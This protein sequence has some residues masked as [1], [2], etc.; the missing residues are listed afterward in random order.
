[1]S[2]KANSKC[3]RRPRR[4]GDQR[5]FKPRHPTPHPRCANEQKP[6]PLSVIHVYSVA[7]LTHTR[8]HTPG[9]SC[10]SASV[11]EGGER[12]ETMI[13]VEFIDFNGA[14]ASSVC[15]LWGHL[16]S[17]SSVLW[18]RRWGGVVSNQ[19]GCCRR[20]LIRCKRPAGKRPCSNNTL[21]MVGG[22]VAGRGGV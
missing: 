1:M 21:A 2:R 13:W 6:G 17:G 4:P 18:K 15:P 11:A 14:R 3:H 5:L 7:L 20:D 12:G 22:W 19:R 16:G 10:W 8:T 9:E